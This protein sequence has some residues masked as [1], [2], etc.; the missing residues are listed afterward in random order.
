MEKTLLPLFGTSVK[1]HATSP[2]RIAVLLVA[3]LL[4]C[5]SVWLLVSELS[6]ASIEHLPVNKGSAAA[7][8]NKR[9][10]AAFAASVGDVRGD[11][12]AQSAYTYADLLWSGP[13]TTESAEVLERARASLDRALD[14]APHRSDVW[15]LLAALAQR[16]GLKGIDP[17]QVLKMSYYT[18]PSESDLIPLHIAIAA[19]S[20][21][22]A[23]VEMREFVSRDLRWLATEKQNSTIAAAY[24]ATSAEGKKFIEQTLAEISPPTLQWLRST[25]RS[26]Q[27]P[28]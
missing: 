2:F 6:G 20:D 7:A 16:Y 18:G 4:A 28:D 12:W 24:N 23:D 8:A 25:T 1:A 17:V 3:F 15:L 13:G 5:Q 14:E 26:S 10:A 22:V 19:K 9:A 27:L 21:F 11:L